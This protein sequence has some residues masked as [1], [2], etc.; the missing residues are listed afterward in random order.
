M[1]M[2]DPL[3]DM[4]ARIRN[5]QK[6]RKAQ[7]AVPA[8][9]LHTAVLGVLKDEGYIRGFADK[10]IRKGVRETIVDLRYHEGQPAIRE[11]E[12]VSSP[13]RRVYSGIKTLA[14]PH[15]G[16]GVAI[17]STPQGVMSDSAA[18]T[19]NVGGEVICRVY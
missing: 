17:V 4:I 10:E 1:S 11:I 15:G 2:S 9:K 19:K 16:L 18:R 14:R 5:G 7:V 6:A 13:G 8:A 3:A 12:R